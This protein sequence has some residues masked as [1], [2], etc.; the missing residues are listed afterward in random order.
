MTYCNIHNILYIIKYIY[1]CIIYLKNKIQYK[2]NLQQ[3]DI[4]KNIWK[5][6]GYNII[7]HPLNLDYINQL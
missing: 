6:P 5:A 3:I 2:N 7:I 1:N 4:Q